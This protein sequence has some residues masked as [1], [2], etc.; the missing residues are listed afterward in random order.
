MCNIDPACQGRELGSTSISARLTMVGNY[1]VVIVGSSSVM[2]SQLKPEAL[3]LILS[4]AYVFVDILKEVT[5][6][7]GDTLSEAQRQGWCTLANV[8]RDGGLNLQE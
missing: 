2:G 6:I 1:L 8:H 4:G 5:N 3:D 7:L